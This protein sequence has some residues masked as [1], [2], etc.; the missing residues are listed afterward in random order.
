MNPDI[1]G[2][3]RRSQKRTEKCEIFHISEYF[4]AAVHTVWL[5]IQNEE[6]ENESKICV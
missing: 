3:E 2:V 1:V 6:T 4:T 5:Q